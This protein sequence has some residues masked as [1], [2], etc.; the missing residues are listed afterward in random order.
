MKNETGYTIK[1][2]ITGQLDG[3][4]II[5]SFNSSGQPLGGRIE[6]RTPDE[7]WKIY[8]VLNGIG[9]DDDKLQQIVASHTEDTTEIDLSILDGVA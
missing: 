8:M 1:Y 9:F 6:V 2:E 7:A 3:S 5:Q 4:W